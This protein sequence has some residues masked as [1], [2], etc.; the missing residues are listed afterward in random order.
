ME[1]RFF[2]SKGQIR[3]MFIVICIAAILAKATGL[4]QT[5]CSFFSKMALRTP[6]MHS[7]HIGEREGRVLEW[8]QTGVSSRPMP[9]RRGWT[10]LAAD[11]DPA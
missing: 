9:T 1:C 2:K 11:G 3:I 8:L 7:H 6:P 5:P 4:I 10:M